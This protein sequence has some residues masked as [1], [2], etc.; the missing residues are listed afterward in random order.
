[1]GILAFRWMAW[2]KALSTIQS[3]FLDVQLGCLQTFL[4]GWTTSKFYIFQASAYWLTFTNLQLMV[5][6]P[7]WALPAAPRH[8]PCLPYV[9]NPARN[10]VCQP[11]TSHIQSS[12][13]TVYFACPPIPAPRLDRSTCS[14]PSSFSSWAIHSQQQLYGHAGLRYLH[15]YCDG[16]GIYCD[17]TQ[18]SWK[19]SSIPT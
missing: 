1:M 12:S 4:A 7:R 9:G 6:T 18:T 8:S 13:S 14:K 15:D 17:G 2:R 16:Q 5:T 19:P 3:L 11:G 10:W